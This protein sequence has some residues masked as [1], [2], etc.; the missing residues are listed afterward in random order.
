MERRLP[1]PLEAE[2]VDAEGQWARVTLQTY[3]GD[4]RWRASR[5]DGREVTV[6]ASQILSLTCRSV[7]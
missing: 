2:V 6:T 4:D 5:D 3:L 1:H 7:A